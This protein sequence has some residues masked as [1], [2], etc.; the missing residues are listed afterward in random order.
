MS[1]NLRQESYRLRNT[2]ISILSTL[3]TPSGLSYRHL[4]PVKEVLPP[5]MKVLT[6]SGI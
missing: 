3:E 1:S 4:E 6:Q 5:S 2:H